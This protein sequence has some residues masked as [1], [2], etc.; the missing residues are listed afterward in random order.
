MEN[1]NLAN[2]TLESFSTY[3]Q[4]YK[5]Y[6]DT[7]KEIKVLDKKIA[8]FEISG[9]QSPDIAKKLKSVA[10]IKCY[11]KWSKE[12]LDDLTD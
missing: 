6:R 4:H 10:E 5:E 1:N 8:S 12:M 2:K 9:H 11:V 3:D 7:V